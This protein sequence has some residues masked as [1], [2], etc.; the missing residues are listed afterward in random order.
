M[1][2]GEL[3]GWSL[4]HE[5]GQ[6]DAHHAHHPCYPSPATLPCCPPC[7]APLTL[8]NRFARSCRLL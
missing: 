2:L 3:S 4:A 5:R 6:S 7:W 1:E 8:A